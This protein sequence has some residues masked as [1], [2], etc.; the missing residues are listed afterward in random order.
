MVNGGVK[1]HDRLKQEI[2]YLRK[3]PLSF[4]GRDRPNSVLVDWLKARIATQLGFDQARKS[5]E[6]TADP[7]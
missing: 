4:L 5:S 7:P 1:D 3:H 2:E 6:D